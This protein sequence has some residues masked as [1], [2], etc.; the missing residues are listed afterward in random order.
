M[1]R[2][3][4]QAGFTL[5]EMIVVTGITIILS[6]ILISYNRSGNEQ[7]ALNV[8]QAKIIGFL[9]RAKAFALEKR[10][11]AG[12]RICAFGLHFEGQRQIFLFRDL[13]DDLAGSCETG[14]NK[15]YDGVIEFLEDFSLAQ[16]MVLKNYPGDIV[17]EPPYL[18]TYNF[19]LIKIGLVA[20]D[21]AICVEVSQGGAIYGR[22]C[23]PE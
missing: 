2:K 4:R 23:P 15:T 12:Q 21:K 7:I 20:G 13:P 22:A 16:E 18:I 11:T 5:T 17:F 6:T 8:E 1:K 9:N 10:I 14:F 3:N 19:G